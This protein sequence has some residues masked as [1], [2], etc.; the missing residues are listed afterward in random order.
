MQIF[1]TA[2][3]LVFRFP[4]YILV[5]IVMMGL[6]GLVVTGAPSS[7]VAGVVNF[8]APKPEIAIVDRDN[9]ELSR[10]LCDFLAERATLVEVADDTRAL[11][12]AV[13]MNAVCY[14]LVIPANYGRDFMAA[15]TAGTAAPELEYITSV[16][17]V[18]AVLV[19]AEVSGYLNAL[20]ITAIGFPE[21]S[22]TQQIK[23]AHE[24][25]ALSSP[26]TVVQSNETI[27]R[28]SLLPFYFR[29]SSY[30]MSSGIAV[31]VAM[32]FSGFYT[33]ELR[34]R[35]LASPIRSVAMNMQ[36]TASCLLIALFTWAFICALSLTPIIGGADLLT[37]SPASYLLVALTALLYTLVPLSIGFLFS[38]FNLKEMAVNGFVNI[39]SL[40]MMFLSGIMMGGSDYLEGTMLAVAR[41]VPTYWYSEAIGAIVTA[42]DLSSSALSY[43]FNCVGLMLL[44]ALVIFSVALL[45]GR[46]RVQSNEAG[47]NTAAEV[48]A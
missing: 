10:G 2:L 36:I 32:V 5:Y 29:W 24:T 38:Q 46:L 25:A 7:N 23:R 22:L 3:R 31:L 1:K 13:A 12:D 11:Q 8:D 14:I 15:A 20:R 18:N 19:D 45:I 6:L 34:R 48:T 47:G 21:L 42:S 39:A 44:F 33:G 30:P 16:A 40:V 43:Y 41:F 37:Q 28:A 9:S 35:N 26:L 17:A 27:N 4:V